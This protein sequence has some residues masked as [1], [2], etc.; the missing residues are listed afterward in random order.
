MNN[1][2]KSDYIKLDINKSARCQHNYTQITENNAE[3]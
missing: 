1:L 2:D 3:Y